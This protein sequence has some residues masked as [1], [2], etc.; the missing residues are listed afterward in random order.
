MTPARRP[1]LLAALL[2][3]ASSSPA[4]ASLSCTSKY[5]TT[6]IINLPTL[7]TRRG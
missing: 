2:L 5:I 7:P 3:L 1:L 4:C 6:S